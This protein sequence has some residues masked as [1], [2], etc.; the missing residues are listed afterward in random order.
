[1]F[2][3]YQKDSPFN[4]NNESADSSNPFDFG[5]SSIENQSSPFDFNKDL[6]KN[7]SPFEF[8]SENS[9]GTGLDIS[10]S[11]K[12]SGS[13]FDSRNDT[14]DSNNF[15]ESTFGEL[16][17]R[18]SNYSNLSVV[19]KM[20]GLTG[21]RLDN[22]T[23]IDL[24]EQYNDSS[25]DKRT[26]GG[27][28]NVTLTDIYT[29][30]TLL[31]QHFNLYTDSMIEEKE[32]NQLEGDFN[33]DS[34]E[35]ASREQGTFLSTLTKSEEMK[36]T[37]K[38]ET[39]EEE[40]RLG[41][42]IKRKIGTSSFGISTEIISA[43]GAIEAGMK[44]AEEEAV[45]GA[46]ALGIF[47]K[48][49]KNAGEEQETLMG[50]YSKKANKEDSEDSEEPEDS[51]NSEESKDKKSLSNFNNKKTDKTKTDSSFYLEKDNSH[52]E[53]HENSE[54]S[55]PLLMSSKTKN[56]G[57]KLLGDSINDTPIGVNKNKTNPEYIRK[58]KDLKIKYGSDL[59]TRE[60]E[61][62]ILRTGKDISPL[63]I[64]VN[65]LRKIKN[66]LEAELSLMEEKDI[67]IKNKIDLYKKI[68]MKK[69]LG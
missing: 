42:A 1:M 35:Q 7:S 66:K 37:A 12:R 19:D 16:N 20:R 39:T 56:K 54:I 61:E 24:N 55:S 5:N 11:L 63:N 21:G 31:N 6:R 18:E 25:L 47:E 29:K 38:T 2:D 65:E 67:R 50:K 45:A 27:A 15:S 23:D 3:N 8:S 4:F 40:T 26:F 10:E 51:E 68:I 59:L 32:N 60:E 53:N 14:K 48:Y 52:E 33:K 43:V 49:K 28:Y 46:A 36:T 22:S 44:T 34:I 17:A 41:K 64:S 69:I 57:K 58:L 62:F 9:H 30:T 13:I